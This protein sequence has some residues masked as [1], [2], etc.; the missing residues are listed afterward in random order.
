MNQTLEQYLHVFVNHCQDNW[1][2]WLAIA[3]FSY[4]NSPHAAT[5]ETPFF[6]NY[7]QHPWKGDD[8]KKEVR[9][10]SAQDFATRM[11]HV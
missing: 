11:K 1:K 8:S 5:H 9:N 10:K 2:E 6:L 7:S 3:E 4:N